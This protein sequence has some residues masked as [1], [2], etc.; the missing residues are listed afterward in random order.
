MTALKQ[1]LLFLTFCGFLVALPALTAQDG[2]PPLPLP[3]PQEEGQEGGDEDGGETEDATSGDETEEG[4]GGGR[5]RGGMRAY[6]RVITGEAVSEA[7]IFTVHRIGEQLLYEIPVTV[8]GREF[9]WVTRV[10]KTAAGAGYGGEEID[11]RVVRWVQRDDRIFLE[12]I[13]YSIVADP[14]DPI[15]LAVQAANNNAIL[16]AFDIMT[17]G[18]NNESV[19]IDVTNLFASEVPEFSARA[20]LGA[21][22]FDRR[23]SYI[24]EAHAF[25]ENVEV[26]AVQTFTR[27]AD[28]G[29][30]RGGAPDGTATIEMAFSMVKLPDEPMTPRPFD[31][32]VGYFTSN[33]TEFSSFG[34]RAEQ[35]RYITRWRLEKQ[36]PTSEVSE[37]V[38]PIVYWID[39]ATPPELVPYVKSGVEAWQPA[40][41]AAG[42]R[43]AILAREAPSA[44]EEPA[45]S[46]EDA[47]HSVIRWLPTTVENASG[48]NIHD[49]R[50]GEILEADIEIHHN[51]LNLARNWYFVQASPL[52]PRA[53]SLPFPNELMGKL[54]EFIVTHE[55]G[56]TLGLLHNQKASSTYPLENLRE[57]EWLRE[58]SHTPTI[59]DYARFNYVAQPEDDIPV[60]L[61]IP[62]IGP[63]D[64]WAI[65]WGYAPIA[66]DE[67]RTTLDEWAREQD[68]TPWYRFSTDSAASENPGELREAVGDSN[69]IEAT[70]LGLRNLERVMEYLLDA[71]TQPGENW[72]DLEE[73]YDQVLDQWLLEMNHVAGLVGGFDWIRTRGGQEALSY[74]PIAPETQ[75]AAVRFLGE[76][77]F[78]TPEFIIRP[79]I[80]RR[81]EREG[82]L[83]RVLRGQRAILASLLDAG[84]FTRLAEQQVLELSSYAPDRFLDDLRRGI[85]TEL[86]AQEVS[87]DTFRRNLQRAYLDIVAARIDNDDA[88]WNDMRAFLRGQLRALE[89]D[90]QAAMS[91]AND[92]DTRYHLEDVRDEITR[93]LDPLR[94][95]P[96]AGAGRG[97]APT[98]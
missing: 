26:R 10:S 93:I 70:R 30:G 56:H 19:V 55:V 91:R 42:F 97:N 21:R 35:R 7:G 31:E 28:G 23:R 13:S 51:V 12:N 25:P 43:N 66:T 22:G 59:M 1:R 9:L 32:R 40:F 72:D 71:G 34:Y 53:R 41:E 24:S 73:L 78:R 6:D 83:E 85:W 39:P 17:R 95:L 38:K 90:V 64:R 52:D 87:T 86:F 68:T 89:G 14:E 3:A 61:L 54:L 98:G 4:R 33:Q 96:D 49:P 5:G 88:R 50:T 63:Y 82:I 75:Q 8:L 62:R 81:F 16:V 18:P 58:M 76:T 67:V 92:S 84:R 20:A 11:Q 29:R 37:P 80:L 74:T 57:E 2:P 77:A 27:P 47:R 79:D 60:D 48:P 69:A 36:D 65:H 46:P 45:W 15:S 44:E 94:R